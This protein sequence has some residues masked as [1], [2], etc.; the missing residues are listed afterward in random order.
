MKAKPLVA[1]NHLAHVLR[2]PLSSAM[3]ALGITSNAMRQI[4]SRLNAGIGGV[5]SS[6]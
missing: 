2:V 3:N 5:N 4:V 1:L 6:N